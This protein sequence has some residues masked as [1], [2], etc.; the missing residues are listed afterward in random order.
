[1]YSLKEKLLNN[2]ISLLV[3]H[4]IADPWVLG[5]NEFGNCVFRSY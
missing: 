5:L 3:L 2:S 1:M 4:F